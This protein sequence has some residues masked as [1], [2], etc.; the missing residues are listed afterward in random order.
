[1][2]SGTVPPNPSN[3]EVPEAKQAGTGAAS[4]LSPGSIRREGSGQETDLEESAAALSDRIKADLKR[5]FAQG[6][7]PAAA[8]Y[9]A[10]F[11]A[12]G[13]SS[14]RAISLIY[15]E[16]CLL[17]EIGAEPDPDRFCARY[18]TWHDS[19]VSQLRY[20]R[21]LSSVVA[22]LSQPSFPQ[23][24]GRFGP[25]RLESILGRGM[26]A[27]VYLARDEEL[28]G[29]PVALKISADRGDEPSIQGRLDHPHIV[30]VLSVVKQPE[31]GLRGLCM[32]YRPGLALD[33]VI[34]RIDPAQ[35][36]K[37]ARSLWDDLISASQ[38]ERRFS[39]DS[40]GWAGF[41]IRGT[42]ADGVA[43]I[44][45][46]LAQ[47]LAHAHERGILH[48]DVKPA[49][50]L[51]TLREGPQL[52]D[53]NLA[54]DPSS[55]EQAEAALRGGT[56]PYMAPEQLEAFINPERWE[57]VGP[58]ADLY[59]LGLVLCELITGRRPSAPPAST[60]L[61]RAIAE[62]LDQRRDLR[63][64]LRAANPA[65]PHA[66]EAIANRCLAAKVEDRYKNASELSQDLERLIVRK[67]LRH[68]PNT[69]TPERAKNLMYRNR[70]AL[71]SVLGL[72]ILS[73]LAAVGL[74][75]PI[76]KAIHDWNIARAESDLDNAANISMKFPDGR[77]DEVRNLL[78]SAVRRAPELIAAREGLG[79]FRMNQGD[80]PGAEE[81]L[82]RALEIAGR[83]VPPIDRMKHARLFQERALN[84][85]VWG[86]ATDAEKTDA[87][88]RTAEGRCEQ[89]LKDLERARALA[90]GSTDSQYLAMLVYTTA[91]AKWGLGKAALHFGDL[92]RAALFLAESEKFGR[93]AIVSRPANPSALVQIQD[94]YRSAAAEDVSLARALLQSG[95]VEQ[96]RPLF[97][98]ASQRAPK[99]YQ[100]HSGLALVAMATADYDQAYQEIS[101]A[102]ALAAAQS[103]KISPMLLAKLYA[104][105]ARSSY[106]LGEKAR[107]AKTDEAYRSASQFYQRAMVDLTESFKLTGSK[108][109]QELRYELAHAE[110][111]FQIGQA[112]IEL[113]FD[114]P[115]H[116]SPFLARAR[117]TVQ[118]VLDLK[119]GEPSTVD[120]FKYFQEAQTT[121]E[122][123]LRKAQE[124]AKSQE[125]A[126]LPP[127]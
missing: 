43:W 34:K 17:E 93:E 75:S 59:A 61:P 80:Y 48:R 104:T 116:A 52:L 67:P 69:S 25:F 77:L 85:A 78:Q 87:A 105:R 9:L 19:L 55:S 70:V 10:Q 24:G 121:L 123:D 60:P 98:R 82:T 22:P 64:S 71:T 79:V 57:N 27:Q 108:P 54:H 101:Q 100:S 84:A 122:S 23:P 66:L 99:L 3:D 31:T 20:H 8:E 88:F 30:S 26:A 92:D 106:G 72:A 95:R 36:P 40:P 49:N 2:R 28:G 6:E 115:E 42:Y 125:S 68:A 51:L 96:A 33:E 74:V 89:A 124:K 118:T 73:I 81:Q 63:V 117:K 16:F 109:D 45:A 11:P 46:I 120:L 102:L 110:T 1:M 90:G 12:L 111:L 119:P 113:H 39:P 37:N 107:G 62:L 21:L 5:R 50:I 53:F 44:I 32:P 56:L 13:H 18:P 127:K 35:K 38:A 76:K 83:T 47:A 103:P 15:E 112:S 29:R 91:R 4:R 58:A 114:R 86:G 7:R 126:A 65:I 94:W 14:E 41:P 97:L